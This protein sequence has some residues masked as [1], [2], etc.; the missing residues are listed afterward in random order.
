MQIISF[1]SRFCLSGKPHSILPL[2][3][4]PLVIGLSFYLSG[5]VFRNAPITTDEHAYVFQA[6]CFADGV[7]A[8]PLPEPVRMFPHEMMI[9][10]EEHGW[11]S[12]YPPAHA[13]WLTP[14]VFFLQNPRIMVALA[15][16]CSLFLLWRLG[17]ALNLPSFL[18]PGLA[19]LSPYFWFMHGTLL[20]HSSGLVA[21]SLLLFS[22]VSW[23]KT[24]MYRWAV[25]AGLAWAWFFLNR[26]YTGFLIAIPFGIDA[27]VDAARGYSRK[28]LFATILFAGSAGLGALIFLLY[29]H[30]AIGDF[31]TPTYL[32]YQASDALG[33]GPRPPGKIPAMH[34]PL[35][36]FKAL[37]EN[38]V[39]LDRWLYGFPG[40]FVLLVVLLVTGWNRRWSPLLVA[41]PCLVW[42]GYVLF[43]F[44]G[45][46]LVGPVYYYE[47]LPFLL[48]LLAFGL[49]RIWSLLSQTR[50]RGWAL[51]VTLP[52]LAAGLLFS[53][54]QGGF[55][56]DWQELTGQYHDL[57][58]N[59]PENSL[60]LVRKIPGMHY[61]TQGMAY[62]PNGIDSDPLVAHLGKLPT[63]F[64][65]RAYPNR[66]PYQLVLKDGNLG[67]QGCQEQPPLVY[68]WHIIQT[69]AKTGDPLALDDQK[70]S[71]YACQ[72]I[73]GADWLS[74][75][76]FFWVVRGDYV[77]KIQLATDGGNGDVP[78]E[79]DIVS[80]NGKKVLAHHRISNGEGSMI[81]I[82]FTVE[83]PRLRVE[84]RVYFTGTGTV[85]AGRMEIFQI[86]DAWQRKRTDS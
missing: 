63:P 73:H 70:K 52:V 62:N 37:F 25:L 22:Y 79:I 9:M 51:A 85:Q 17:M 65:V 43:W 30:A 29:N 40:G 11:L 27:L 14:G 6:N 61:M 13:A 1:F 60:I 35:I 31:L 23:K 50:K 10:D 80:D 4:V 38:L 47:T 36:G 82:P 21:V 86:S 72:G 81:E 46:R 19:V 16:V 45:I 64:L 3:A 41:V 18:L 57:L 20:S 2:A 68:R 42:L 76:S 55:L 69:R 26:T 32:Y 67:L 5:T 83:A 49:R 24:G 12:R 33:F 56:R 58:R 75:G 74:F 48:L 44:E 39:L 59:A 66:T 78:V 53:W 34:T 7:L 84:P 77:L 8:R 71:R 28:K 54:Q 15:A